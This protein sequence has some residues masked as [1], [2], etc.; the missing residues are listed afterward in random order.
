MNPIDY[1]LIVLGAI[2]AVITI[3]C[4]G[5]VILTIP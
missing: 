3:T 2:F 1:L 5:V 4:T